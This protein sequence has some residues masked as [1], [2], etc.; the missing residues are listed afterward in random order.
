MG[1]DKTIGTGNKDFFIFQ[2]P[3]RIWDQISFVASISLRE[4]GNGKTKIS[5]MSAG[6][7]KYF[8]LILFFKHS[9]RHP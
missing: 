9:L 2:V 6:F 5:V 3:S 7:S 1:P 4:A 8:L